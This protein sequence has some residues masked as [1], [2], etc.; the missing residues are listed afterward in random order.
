MHDAVSILLILPQRLRYFL[1]VCSSTVPEAK[2]SFN[3]L[4]NRHKVSYG[5]SSQTSMESSR[6]DVWNQERRGTRNTALRLMPYTDEP[7]CHATP[8]ALIPYQ[9]L[10]SWIKITAFLK[11]VIFWWSIGDL[12][13][14]RTARSVFRGS[15]SPPDCHSLPLPFKSACTQ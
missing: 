10:R 8:K 6:S 7:R 12:I 2:I 9:A 13:L 3:Q 1:K 5:I 15:D 14:A 4:S 11:A